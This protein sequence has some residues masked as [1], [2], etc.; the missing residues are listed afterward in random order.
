M[1]FKCFLALISLV[2]LTSCQ[3]EQQLADI[4]NS[5]KEYIPSTSDN[6]IYFDMPDLTVQYSHQNV[7]YQLEAFKTSANDRILEEKDPSKYGQLLWVSLGHP[8]IYKSTFKTE[9]KPQFFHFNNERFYTYLSMLETTH[10]QIF[11]DTVLQKHNVSISL[12]QIVLLPLSQLNCKI[13]F[14]AND[15]RKIIFSGEVTDFKTMPL[16]IDFW[17]PSQVITH[18]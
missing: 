12:S 14:N 17:I 10:K 1:I 9:E 15:G 2:A 11:V 16:Q 5:L 3:D 6:T 4:N 7:V 8:L 18:F 13:R